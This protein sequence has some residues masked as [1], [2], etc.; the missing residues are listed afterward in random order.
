MPA[1]RVPTVT[2]NRARNMRLRTRLSL[3]LAYMAQRPMYEQHA[4]H[5]GNKNEP[6]LEKMKK[7]FRPLRPPG[8][9]DYTRPDDAQRIARDSDGQHQGHKNDAGPEASLR[10]IPVGNNQRDQRHQ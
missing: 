1:T 10:K 8:V 6:T 2:M 3:K 5:S 4:R 7:T 9:S